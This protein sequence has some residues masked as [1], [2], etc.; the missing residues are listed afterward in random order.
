MAIAERAQEVGT[1]VIRVAVLSGRPDMV[2]GGDALIEVTLPASVP[3]SSA[4]ISVDGQNVTAAFKSGSTSGSLVGLVEGLRV[5]KNTVR[6]TAGTAS[7]QLELTDYPITG[8]IFSRPH[9]KPFVCNTE[10]NGLGKPLDADCSAPTKFEYFY[11]TVVGGRGGRGRGGAAPGAAGPANGAIEPTE[12]AP[13]AAEFRS[14]DPTA[15]RPNNIA[16]TTTREGRTVP[17]IVRVETGT[18]NRM[19]YRIAILDDPSNPTSQN[20]QWTPGPGWNHRIVVTFGGGCAAKYTQGILPPTEVLNDAYLSRGFAVTTT[21]ANAMNQ[22]CNDQIAAETTMMIKEH[23]IKQYGKPVWTQGVGGSAGGIMQLLVAQ[24]YPGLLD[25]LLPSVP[26][27]DQIMVYTGYAD[28]HL[29]T[30]YFKN[31]NW[32]VEKQDAVSGHAPGTCEQAGRTITSWKATS[33]ACALPMEM[34]YDAASTPKG[35]RCDIWDENANTWGRDPETGFGRRTF[36]NIGWQYGLQALNGGKITPAEFIDLNAKIGGFDND[37]ND[38]PTRSVGDLSA[39]RVSYTVGRVQE[40]GGSLG[41]IP[42]LDIRA[43]GDLQPGGNVHDRVRD[44]IIRERIKYGNNGRADNFVAWLTPPGTLS[45]LVADVAVD[46][47]DSWLDAIANDKSSD[48]ATVKVVRDKP[49][50]AVDACWDSNVVRY[51]EPSRMD[52]NGRCNQLYPNHSTPRIVAGA[53]LRD[54][55]MKCQLKPLNRAEYKVKF[56]DTEWTQMQQ[57]FASGVCDFSKPGVNQDKFAG[58]WQIYPFDRAEPKTV[59]SASVR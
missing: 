3:A 32:S 31:T 18:I 10:E 14:F 27:A 25:G 21:P 11:R 4:A 12:A 19:I 38:R 33:T 50:N 42:I 39:I 54:D 47:L 29:L 15:P 48:P 2:S 17:Y 30:N 8:P 57:V 23:F 58:G 56:T 16:Q 43:Y 55:V 7:A 5:G 1:N 40:G 49:A 26:F 22:F 20:K 6:A 13:V 59:A 46:T 41:S 44:H 34:V 28:C 36:D 24:N 45:N 53:S 35:A 37:G 51:N 9:L 52:G